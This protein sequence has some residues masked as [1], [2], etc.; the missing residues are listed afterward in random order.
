MSCDEY[1]AKCREASPR[2]R[3]A[4]NVR[5]SAIARLEDGQWVPVAWLVNGNWYRPFL[6][7]LN[8]DSMQGD[9]IA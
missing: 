3:Y 6:P 4:R 8:V 1:L 9:W 2:I 5:G 7:Y